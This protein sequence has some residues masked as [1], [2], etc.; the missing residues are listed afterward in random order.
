VLLRAVLAA[1]AL[2]VVPVGASAST[3]SVVFAD[4][5]Q[6]DLACSK[7]GG[8]G[9]VPITTFQGAPG[10]ANLVG[11]R[12]DGGTFVVRD[13][14]AALAAASPCTSVDAHSARCP[15]TE[16]EYGLHGLGVALGDGDDRLAIAGDLR[17]ATSISGG[18]GK[19]VIE[20]GAEPDAVDGG[21]GGDRLLGGGG[22][23][24]LSYAAR[25]A[26]V[27]ASLATG[28]GGQAGEDDA[29]GNFEVLV[30]GAGDD[31]LSGA[32]LAETID[33]GPGD[34]VLRGRG[35]DDALFGSTGADRLSGQNGD[36][37]LYGDP[38]QGDDYYTPIIRL[39]GDRLDGGRGDDELSDTGGRNSF[40][41]GP[42]A[43]VLDGGADADR[44]DAGSGPD[45]VFARGGGRDRVRC[46]TG[47]DRAVTDRRDTRRSCERR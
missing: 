35:G 38:A 3:V 47:A 39:R 30:G 6:D 43:D 41:G 28:S 9:P 19:D 32:G 36:D 7:Y 5:C 44:M 42:G 23:D 2:L 45:V 1:L 16:G 10:E 25:T 40:L 14:G 33:G 21:A 31:V 4:G 22:V 12:R 34:D 11:V 18:D 15:V 26:P 17:V 8:A 29:F 27:V 20:A 37:R 24:E 46:G 13:D